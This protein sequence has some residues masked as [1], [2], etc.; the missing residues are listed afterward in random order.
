MI[1]FIIIGKNEGER[2]EKSISSVLNVIELDNIKDSEIIYVDSKSSDDS[3]S[4]AMSMGVRT[5][6]ITGECNAAIARN[7]GAKE[8]KGNILFFLDGDMEILPGFLQNIINEGNMTY[9]FVSGI[10]DDIVYNQE[11]KYQHTSRRIKLNEGD[12]DLIEY[13]TGGLFIIEKAL[14]EKVNGMDSIFT[15]SQDYDLGLRLA[16]LGIPLHRKAILLAKHHTVS[17][18]RRKWDPSIKKYASL[19][20]RKHFFNPYCYDTVIRGQYSSI[21]LLL[22]ICMSIISP[23]FL[24][25][26]LFVLLYKFYRVGKI[27]KQYHISL[28]YKT[29]V[30]DILFFWYL[31][32]YFPKVK[33]LSYIQM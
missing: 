18:Y 28:F 13:T 29:I 4:I 9:P 20:L 5:F 3:L 26:Y 22:S 7:I 19:I 2:L 10:F 24:L 16:K 11:W 1:S 21:T 15:K 12:K 8:S 14:W 23:L 17:Y 33:E 25:L 6:L 31:F 30:E 27:D 32:T